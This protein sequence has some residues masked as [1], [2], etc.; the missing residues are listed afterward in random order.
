MTFLGK[1][2]SE[3]LVAGCQNAM[4]KIDIE[5]GHI[6]EEVRVNHVLVQLHLLIVGR[7]PQVPST[8]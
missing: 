8:L 7:F 2:N 3:I 6:I 5:R 4:F 1:S